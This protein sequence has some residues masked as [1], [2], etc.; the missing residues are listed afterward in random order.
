[1]HF[2]LDLICNNITFNCR[3][4]SC[5]PSSPAVS[6]K[7]G[8]IFGG[9]SGFESRT[10]KGFGQQKTVN[11]IWNSWLPASGHEIADALEFERYSP[12]LDAHTDNGGQEIRLPVKG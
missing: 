10:C 9:R 8:G 6:P 2:R 7:H 3:K 12:G 5:Q 4:R 11:T 1:M